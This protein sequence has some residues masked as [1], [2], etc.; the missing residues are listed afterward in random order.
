MTVEALAHPSDTRY[1]STETVVNNM[2]TK[3][4]A[5]RALPGDLDT[6]F[7]STGEVHRPFSGV[8]LG[9]SAYKDSV[10]LTSRRSVT[11]TDGVFEVW[12]TN[13]AGQALK[14]WEGKFSAAGFPGYARAVELPN[15]QFLVY[16]RDDHNP[17]GGVG[18]PR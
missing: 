12:V 17:G 14:S 3:R 13:L 1:F 4:A 18:S 7:N 2:H 5:E 6:S 10:C 9:A 15:R 11:G 8:G 16:G